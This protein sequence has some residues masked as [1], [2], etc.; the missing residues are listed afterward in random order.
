MSNKVEDD[1]KEVYASE[2][3]VQ[4]LDADV[5]EPAKRHGDIIDLAARAHLDAVDY[6][7]AESK[8]V[9]RKIDWRLMP[10]LVWVCES[11][12]HPPG[13]SRY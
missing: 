6:T 2:I 10:L 13:S 5:D 11:K 7:E 4:E 3:R 12:S 9:L 1:S 8:A